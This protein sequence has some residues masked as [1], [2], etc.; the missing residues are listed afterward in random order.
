MLDGMVEAEINVHAFRAVWDAYSH[1]RLRDVLEHLDPDIEWRQALVP[2]TYV[3]F[4][5]LGHWVGTMRQE[6]KSMTIVFEDM[7][8]V[9][10]DCVVAFGRMTAFD[11]GGEQRHDSDLAWVAEF[12][13]GLMVRASAFVDRGEAL[14]YVTARREA[15]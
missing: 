4:A 15:T 7:R 6:W 14:R 2:E 12:R 9:A 11:N 8:A 5:R 13:D 10:D 1:G 3:G